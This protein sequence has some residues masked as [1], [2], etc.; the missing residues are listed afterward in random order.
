MK[1]TDMDWLNSTNLGVWTV[2]LIVCELA[3]GFVGRRVLYTVVIT[4]KH[5]TFRGPCVFVTTGLPPPPRGFDSVTTAAA[6]RAVTPSR[7][8][9]QGGSWPMPKP[10]PTCNARN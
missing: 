6:R 8:R 7:V 3:G 4:R 1:Y 2:W 10:E 9:S 5:V